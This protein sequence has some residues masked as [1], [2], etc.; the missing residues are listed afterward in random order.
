MH[1]SNLRLAF[2]VS[3]GLVQQYGVH[4]GQPLQRFP[5]LEEDAELRAA[6]DG[7]GERCRYG[8]SHGT[9]A[10]N[11][12]H[13]H[14]GGKGKTEVAMIECQPGE[15]GDQCQRENDGDEDCA[16]RVR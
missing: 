5:A 11:D 3:A 4:V 6:S 7:D 8:K 10:G 2:Q 14:C 12:Q 13:G 16:G 15:E 9:G 1:A